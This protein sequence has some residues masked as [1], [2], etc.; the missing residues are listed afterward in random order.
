MYLRATK[1]ELEATGESAE[2]MAETTSKLRASL[3][4]LSHQKV[5][6]LDSN[7]NYKST[8]AII[9]EMGAA[10]SEMSDQ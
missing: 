9:K 6:I 3:Y 10:W 4:A 1:T 5:D 2:G 7:G 8:F